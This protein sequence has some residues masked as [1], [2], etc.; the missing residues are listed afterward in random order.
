MIGLFF[1]SKRYSEWVLSVAIEFVTLQ[2]FICFKT[3]PVETLVSIYFSC[4]SSKVKQACLESF[5]AYCFIF[6]SIRSSSRAFGNQFSLRAHFLSSFPPFLEFFFFAIC[7]WSHLVISLPDISILHLG[8]KTEI[9]REKKYD[10]TAHPVS[11]RI[12]KRRWEFNDQFWL[13]TSR[14]RC[15]PITVRYLIS[16][17]RRT[18][19]T[20]DNETIWQGPF[21]SRVFPTRMNW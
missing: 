2:L 6:D 3:W 5:I 11:R 9:L 12:A 19:L 21:V 1:C 14:R 13:T 16:R 10:E 8:E 4:K 7:S 15:T 20:K 17:V 18:T